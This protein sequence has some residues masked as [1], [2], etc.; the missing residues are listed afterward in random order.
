MQRKRHANHK[1]QRTTTRIKR[2]KTHRKPSKD[3]DL[4]VALPWAYQP[5]RGILY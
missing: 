4:D 1:K 3:D 2:N 5:D